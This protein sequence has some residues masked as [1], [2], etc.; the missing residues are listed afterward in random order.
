MSGE[1]AKAIRDLIAAIDAHLIAHPFPGLADVR[2]GI[3]AARAGAVH[4][5]EPA[6]PRCGF[7]DQS[8]AA[9]RGADA[10]QS[11]IAAAAPLLR[12]VTYDSYPRADIG[13][14][15][16]K[17][18][19]FASIIGSGAPVEAEDF[20]LGL[21]LIAPHVLYR[22]HHHAAPELYAPLTGPHRWRFGPDL[23]WA[24]KPAHEPV[25][26]PPWQVHATLTGDVP[27]LCVFCWTRDVNVPAKVVFAKDWDMLEARL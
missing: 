26:N 17:A 13:E 2:A 19:A 27:F 9:V 21:F 22:D 7:L 8:I 3:E 25:W 24:V 4:H 11:A 23:A 14:C 18:H 16:P 12:W 10:L 6:P 1:S 15:F 5:V 20:D